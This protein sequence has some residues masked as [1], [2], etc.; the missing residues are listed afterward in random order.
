[1]NELI[2]EQLLKTKCVSFYDKEGQQVPFNEIDKQDTLIVKP[3]KPRASSD[4]LLLF[5]FEDYL[6]KPFS[7]FD[8][9]ERFNKGINIPLKVMQGKI[10]RTIGKMYYIKVKGFYFKTNQCVH[11]LK[12]EESNPVCKDCFRKLNVN[13][14]EEITWEGYVPQKGCKEVIEI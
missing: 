11:C 13:D 12:N 6:I 5:T 1:M 3:K 9:H 2:K 10:I 4:S 14:I 8:F 7:G